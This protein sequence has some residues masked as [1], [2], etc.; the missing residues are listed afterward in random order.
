M[1][2]TAF[3]KSVR[4][5]PRKVRYVADTIRNLSV[6]EALKVLSVVSRR[7]S[8]ALEKTLESAIANAV[9]NSKA[10]RVDLTI[11]SLEVM[12][13]P[14]FKRFHPSTRGRIHPYKKKTSHIKIT[15]EGKDKKVE[16]KVEEKVEEV[17]EENK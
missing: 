16:K 3:A 14:V 7:G 17:T 1:E 10:D 2:V 5:S 13:G 9:N 4:V 11:K 6:E 8:Y 12:E 15:L